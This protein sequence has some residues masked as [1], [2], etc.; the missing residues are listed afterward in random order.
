MLVLRRIDEEKSAFA[1][2][3]GVGPGEVYA[4]IGCAAELH[5]QKQT[6]CYRYK[7]QAQYPNGGLHFGLLAPRVF[8][9]SAGK[10]LLYGLES[11]GMAAT[12]EAAGAR[13]L[14]DLQQLSRNMN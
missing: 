13:H 8:K 1:Q 6:Y 11:N 10:I 9:R 5:Q 4:K 7:S 14:N 3:H 12:L 2:E